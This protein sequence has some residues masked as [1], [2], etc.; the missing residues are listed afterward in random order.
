MTI[1]LRR[2]GG[3]RVSLLSRRL[4][5]AVKAEPVD[6][7]VIGVI[8]PTRGVIPVR[9]QKRRLRLGR[10]V[11]VDVC[12]LSGVPRLGGLL[13]LVERRVEVVPPSEGLIPRGSGAGKVFASGVWGVTLQP[14]WIILVV[15]TPRAV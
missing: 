10:L 4:L 9:M 15:V 13:R 6:N 14:N 5:R 12:M 1:N 3:L 2:A 7:L 11:D 8:L